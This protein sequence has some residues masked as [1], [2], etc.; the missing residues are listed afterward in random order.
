MKESIADRKHR[1]F[2]ERG[3]KCENCGSETANDYQVHHC[4]F[5]NVSKPA[6]LKK[7]LNED[8]N[9]MIVCQACHPFCNGYRVRRLFWAKQVRRYKIGVMMAWYDKVPYKDKPRFW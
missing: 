5:H 4:L 6:W 3:Y 1:L 2:R 9:L 7:L 8:M